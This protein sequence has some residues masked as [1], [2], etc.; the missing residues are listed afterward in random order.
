MQ[1][2][3]NG[4]HD[5]RALLRRHVGQALELRP[6]FNRPP[7]RVPDLV[8][9]LPGRRRQAARP[10]ILAVIDTSGSVT[11]DLLERID[12]ELARLSKQFAVTVVECDSAIRRVYPT[13]RWSTSSAGVAPT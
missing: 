12:A 3:S 6:V 13:A 1:G 2:S 4:N 10:R 5:W 8:G 11:D 7:R 9:V